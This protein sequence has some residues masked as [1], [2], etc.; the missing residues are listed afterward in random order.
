[1]A[2]PGRSPRAR[3]LPPARDRRE[4]SRAAVQPRLPTTAPWA[5][6]SGAPCPQRAAA[7][8]RPDSREARSWGRGKVTMPWEMEGCGGQQAWAAR[9]A[10][11]GTQGERGPTAALQSVNPLCLAGT[12]LADGRCRISQRTEVLGGWP[13]CCSPVPLSCPRSPLCSFF[14][15]VHGH[16]CSPLGVT[17]RRHPRCSLGS[18]Q[19]R[20]GGA[21]A[22]PGG[23]ARWPR[24]W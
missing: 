19:E 21:K 3:P 5:G 18:W 23:W 8:Q 2:V 12:A 4:L 9:G 11:V 15:G 7:R 20:D 22:G 13:A 1:M 24:G 14:Q 6:Q 17:A 16:P 10:F